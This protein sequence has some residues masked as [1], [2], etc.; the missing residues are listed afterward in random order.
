LKNFTGIDSPY[1]APEAPEIHLDAANMTPD[2][3]ADRVIA[4]MRKMELLRP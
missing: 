1:E 3:A 2:E 4:V